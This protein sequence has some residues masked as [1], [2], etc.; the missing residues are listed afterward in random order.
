MKKLSVLVLALVITLTCTFGGVVSADTSFTIDTTAISATKLAGSVSVDFGVAVNEASLD[1]R[2]VLAKGSVEVPI[3]VAADGTGVKVSYGDLV[4]DSA[5]TLTFKAGITSADGTKTLATD[6]PITINTNKSV[7]RI[8]EDFSNSQ[9][10]ALETVTA[11]TQLPGTN[12]YYIGGGSIV[13]AAGY[14]YFKTSTAA[15]T[16]SYL[17]DPYHTKVS[18]ANETKITEDFVF[19]LDFAIDGAADSREFVIASDKTAAKNNQASLT[20]MNGGSATLYYLMFE[21]TTASSPMIDIVGTVTDGVETNNKQQVNFSDEDS[22]GFNEVKM[23]ACKGADGNYDME[24]TTEAVCKMLDFDKFESYGSFSSKVYNGDVKT[25]ETM[26]RKINIYKISP[27]DILKS[28]W[29]ED[30]STYDITVTDD[31]ATFGTDSYLNQANY[32]A[33]TRTFK[34]PAASLGAVVTVSLAGMRTDDGAF[35]NESLNIVTVDSLAAVTAGLD[36]SI[37]KLAGQIEVPFVAELDGASLK[38][39]VS[40]KESVSGTET[41]IAV[42]L[43]DS[44]EKTVVVKYG[45]LEEGKTYNLTFG[46]G[47]KSKTGGLTP[48]EAIVIPLNTNESVYRVK[49]DFQSYEEGD[50]VAKTTGLTEGEMYHKGSGKIKTTESGYKY[51]N[52]ADTADAIIADPYLNGA[53]TSPVITEDFAIDFE[54][55]DVAESNIEKNENAIRNFTIAPNP[56]SKDPN[57]DA[58]VFTIMPSQTGIRTKLQLANTT[59][60]N[61]KIVMATGQPT[62]LNLYQNEHGFNTVKIVGYMGSDSNFDLELSSE[63]TANP[64]N[65]IKVDFDKFPSYGSFWSRIRNSETEWGKMCVYKITPIGVLDTYTDSDYLYVVMNDD[66]AK[67]SATSPVFTKANYITASRTFKVSLA[68]LE[69]GEQTYSYADLRTDDG[70]FGG[71]SITATI[72]AAVFKLSKFTTGMDSITATIAPDVAETSPFVAIAVYN[73]KGELQKVTAGQTTETTVT[74]DVS[75]LNPSAGWYAKGFIWDSTSN[76]RPIAGALERP[77]A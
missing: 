62:E 2:V 3:K 42:S 63:N 41:P 39:N 6:T 32:N 7:Y 12:L 36:T 22:D 26:Y 11:V 72:P 53:S 58:N 27:L 69:E 24:V 30:K 20:V 76:I 55:R 25:G 31:I 1:G 70:A 60:A 13:Q 21:N 46:K 15:K 77:W 51:V 67:F 66:I 73:D 48:A 68:D 71:G 16:N 43:K 57:G 50:Y 19:E 75:D 35:S 34:I 33:A 5:Y 44:D 23:V 52:Y 38:G 4:A 8:K 59:V 37:N 61:P 29:S 45:D 18:G 9:A 49:E 28:D 65:S 54:F 40:L 47:L 14:K 10:G 74:L 17:Y 64:N 56:W